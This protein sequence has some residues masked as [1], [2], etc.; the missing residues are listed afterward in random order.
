MT[1]QLINASSFSQH[2]TLLEDFGIGLYQEAFP[3]PD[4]R[5]PFEQIVS[6]I[7]EAKANEPETVAVIA[8]EDG[9]ASAGP[10][11]GSSSQ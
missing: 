5:E 9:K 6:R 11:T 4:E 10:A 3:D 8:G 7:R 2:E 1:F